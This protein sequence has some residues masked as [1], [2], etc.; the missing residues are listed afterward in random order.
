M[1]IDSRPFLTTSSARRMFPDRIRLL[2]VGQPPS[3][4]VGTSHQKR[5]T[6]D[7]P[8]ALS[9]RHRQCAL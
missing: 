4:S 9:I 3:G 8:P 7:T 2:P 1:I 6:L 5:L